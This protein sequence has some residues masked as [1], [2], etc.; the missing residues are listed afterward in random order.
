MSTFMQVLL[1]PN[2]FSV[3][4]GK[5][6]ATF[7]NINQDLLGISLLLIIIIMIISIWFDDCVQMPDQIS[8]YHIIFQVKLSH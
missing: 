4:Q 6:F 2:E 8:I 5:M 1:D 7:N 3:L